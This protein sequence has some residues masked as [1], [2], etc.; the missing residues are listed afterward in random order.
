MLQLP[1]RWLCLIAFCAGLGPAFGHAGF[2]NETEVRIFAD[3]MEVNVRA[4]LGFAWKV[5]GDRA[6]ADT[7]EAGQQIAVPLLKEEALGFFRVT[8][9]EKTMAPRSSRCVFEVDQH[10]FL[11][12]IYDRPPA[13]PLVLEARYFDLFDPLTYGTIKVFDQTD[14][15]YRRDIEPVAVEKIYRTKS[16]FAYDPAPPAE[17]ED[18]PDK[19]IPAQENA[20]PQGGGVFGFRIGGVLAG[21]AIML[22]L[23][24]IIRRLIR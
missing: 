4:T 2:E 20:A 18:P 17:A 12:I 23:I 7:G 21:F 5:M 3:R 15:P 13:W 8:S 9:A 10:V 22:A 19:S 14:A 24:W 11:Q 1:V 16:V 6:P